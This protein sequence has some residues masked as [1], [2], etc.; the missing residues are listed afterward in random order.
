[1]SNKSVNGRVLQCQVNEECSI[2]AFSS[3]KAFQSHQRTHKPP[4]KKGTKPAAANP[5]KK[6]SSEATSA[7]AL[8]KSF[9]SINVKVSTDSQNG[10]EPHKTE[11]NRNPKS[12]KVVVSKQPPQQKRPPEESNSSISLKPKAKSRKIKPQ[13][14]GEAVVLDQT[15][16]RQI[17]SG[18]RRFSVPCHCANCLP[19]T[20]L[21]CEN[22]AVRSGRCC[23]PETLGQ[24]L[25][26]LQVTNQLFP[27]LLSLYLCEILT[28]EADAAF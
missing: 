4:R 2:M 28:L 3:V 16:S 5:P 14:I 17:S 26:P 11:V 22:P 27:S 20:E 6:T 9:S 21:C 15:D 8:L 19:C 12:T 7:K 13:K 10:N 24:C 23:D 1:M 25:Q 18:P